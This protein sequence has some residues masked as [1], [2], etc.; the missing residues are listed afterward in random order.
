MTEK[1][2]LY[3]DPRKMM[4]RKRWTVQETGQGIIAMTGYAC[5]GDSDMTA[6]CTGKE[7]QDRIRQ[8]SAEKP[9]EMELYLRIA[10]WLMS[11]RREV[12]P[13][14]GHAMQMIHLI[15]RGLFVDMTH[16]VLQKSELKD[17][18]LQAKKEAVTETLSLSSE[19]IRETV[20]LLRDDMQT[21]VAF[22]L[23][24]NFLSGVY[25]IDT[26][27]Y[28][29]NMDPDGAMYDEI[30]ILDQVSGHSA[31]LFEIEELAIPQS[32]IDAVREL[33]E[34]GYTFGISDTRL[35]DLLCT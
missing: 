2:T 26:F 27:G 14:K 32:K 4:T 29:I 16:D 28:Q 33:V 9:R 30:L 34:S 11:R 19:Q 15:W 31:G 3:F 17:E 8:A 20:A 24:M 12:L 1:R 6:L 25:Q 21:I 5:M 13:L 23:L 22:N 7:M 18:R 10:N 35:L